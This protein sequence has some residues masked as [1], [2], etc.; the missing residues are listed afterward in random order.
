MKTEIRIS[1]IPNRQ[2][3]AGN[4]SVCV[5]SLLIMISE[6]PILSRNVPNVV[7]YGLVLA[8]FASSFNLILNLEIARWR[9]MAWLGIYIVMI[10]AY[11]LLKVSS[12]DISYYSTTVKFFFFLAAMLIAVGHMTRRQKYL[13]V[14]A[15][16]ISMLYT[17]FDNV[18]LFMQYGST[19]FIHLFQ[20][21]R[22]TT[23]S[24]NTTFVSSQMFFLG[25]FFT[26]FL[27]TGRKSLKLASA[28]M[29]VLNLVFIA[30]M[31]QRMIIF[32]LSLVMLPFIALCNREFTKKRIIVTL[33]FASVLLLLLINFNGV[34]DILDQIID[35]PRL[36]LRF[37]QLKTFFS[38]E[39][40]GDPGG[41]MSARLDLYLR[42][43][44]TWFSSPGRFLL[45]AG[46]HRPMYD[47][48][49]N[50]SCYMDECARYG[51]FGMLIWIPMTLSYMKQIGTCAG[52]RKGSTLMRQIRVILLTYIAN[53]VLSAVY[54]A[55]VGIQIFVLLPVVFSLIQEK[56]ES[57]FILA[58][59]LH[60]EVGK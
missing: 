48:I 42:S 7:F 24:V 4:L 47:I 35:S 3:T 59:M 20:N 6:I 51:L 40:A 38:R 33:F 28:A 43:I 58:S 18:R 52:I 29:V 55:T 32:G 13:I 25:I 31:A 15:V 45:G 34:L 37:E 44:T 17:V 22:F 57:Q 19:R 21:E 16:L 27:R 54:E 5:L 1:G 30:T 12:S 41:S 60:L 26:V 9:T 11:K 8:F 46:D 53:A 36:H 2:V 14:A 50:H 39:E 56:N 49:G 10:M 23:N